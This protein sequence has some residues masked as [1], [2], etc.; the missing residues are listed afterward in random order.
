VIENYKGVLIVNP[1]SATW[2]EYQPKPGTV[3]L[4]E[5]NSENVNASI[6]QLE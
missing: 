6:I 5:I 3:A 4:L 1:G 2:P